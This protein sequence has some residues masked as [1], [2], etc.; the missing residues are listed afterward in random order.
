MIGDIKSNKQ[1]KTKTKTKQLREKLTDPML[2]S[3][4]C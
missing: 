2:T 4:S 3:H 1:K